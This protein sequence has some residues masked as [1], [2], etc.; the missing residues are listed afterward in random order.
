MNMTIS[1]WLFICL[2]VLTISTPVWAADEE[3]PA[4]E[5]KPAIQYVDLAPPI[6]VNVQ[7]SGKR[8][9]FL[10]VKVAI[11]VAGEDA[12]E[13]IRYHSAPLRNALIMLLSDRKADALISADAREKLR[14]EAL[15]R[16]RKTM[17]EIDKA[18]KVEDLLFTGY[19]VQ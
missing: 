14:S 4:E 8:T 10:Q 18:L 13:E 2:G 16:I 7:A 9:R 19:V 11:Q 15:E 3:A 1:R 6:I 5:E 17:A 12:A